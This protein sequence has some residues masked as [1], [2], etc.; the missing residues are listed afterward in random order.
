[1]HGH[2]NIERPTKDTDLCRKK[3]TKSRRHGGCFPDENI[4]EDCYNKLYKLNV[5]LP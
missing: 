3:K 1:M 5:I 4:H 2:L